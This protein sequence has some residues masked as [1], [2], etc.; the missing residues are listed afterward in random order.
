MDYELEFFNRPQSG[1]IDMTLKRTLETNGYRQ[2]HLG[3]AGA[4]GVVAVLVAW[5]AWADLCRIAVRDQE[6]SQV[7]LAPFLA[8]WLFWCRRYRIRML[9]HRR[10]WLGPLVV[11]AGV[12][13]YVVGDVALIVSAWYLGAILM[14]VGAVVT[15]FGGGVLYRFAPAFLVL[16]FLI[17][18]PASVR[19]HIAGPL[20]TATAGAVESVFHFTGMDVSRSGNLLIVN[21]KPVTVAEACNGMRMTFALILVTYTYVFST[22]IRLWMRGVL[23]LASPLIA[24]ACNV[25]RLVPT[26]W[27]YGHIDTQWADF[28][29]DWGAWLMLGVS[30]MVVMGVMQVLRWLDLPLYAYSRAARC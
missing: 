21:G 3:V 8:V 23:L 11:G 15:A 1:A 26:L 2:W 17:P 20:Q 18:I 30:L 9:L 27:A 25:I 7:M 28:I 12:L 16:L 4:L 6:A 14:L 5:P 13:A 29:H 24:V 10:D 19:L 22:P